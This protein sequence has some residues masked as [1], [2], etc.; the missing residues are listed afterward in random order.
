MADGFPRV[1]A[2]EVPGVGQMYYL[3]DENYDF[4]PEVKQFLDFKR[5]VGRAPNTLEAY[6]S[7]LAYF[8]RFLNQRQLCVLATRDRRQVDSAD[9]VAFLMWLCNSY[10]DAG[11]V[12][13][14][15]RESPFQ[16]R[17]VNLILQAVG[18]LYGYLVRHG[19]IKES[20]LKYVDVPRTHWLKERDMLAHTRT[21]K[22]DNM[23]KRMELKLKEP[24]RRPKTVSEGDFNA[25]LESIHVEE[26]PN[27]D[28]SGFR[29]RVICL[30]LKEGGFRIGELLGMRLEDIEKG[31]G[32]VHVRFRPRNV[33]HRGR[34]R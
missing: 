21:G 32:G 10:R 16:A 30:M 8:Y 4:I 11:N 26:R 19:R 33:V 34:R 15:Y 12:D 13:V 17:T 6:G 24:I 9:M 27:R 28:P 22:D 1:M 23:V 31:Q 14:V 29:D 18:S 5:A 2:A 20:P 3:L 7:R 25:F